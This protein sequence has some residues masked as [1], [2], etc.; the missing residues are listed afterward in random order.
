ML[1]YTGAQ[2]KTVKNDLVTGAYYDDIYTRVR[3]YS[4]RLAYADVCLTL[5]FWRML[6]YA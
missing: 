4:S 3:L 2:E 5:V 6:T 1:T